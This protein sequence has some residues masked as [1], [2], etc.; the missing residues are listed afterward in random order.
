MDES[1]WEGQVMRELGCCS[2][3][4]GFVFLLLLLFF[5]AKKSL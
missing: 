5:S 3:E 4:L 2:K 1:V